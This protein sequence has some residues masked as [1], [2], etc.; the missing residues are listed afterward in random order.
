[1]NERPVN[2]AWVKCSTETEMVRS[3][4]TRYNPSALLINL[5]LTELPAS[6]PFDFGKITKKKQLLPQGMG[7]ERKGQAIS[8]SRL[9]ALSIWSQMVDHP[10]K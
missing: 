7:K 1:M 6:Q 5:Y 10:A 4:S 2:K 9:D 3:M 8:S